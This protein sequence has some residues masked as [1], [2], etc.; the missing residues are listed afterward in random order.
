ML[1]LP[2]AVRS[3]SPAH[4]SYVGTGEVTF[5]EFAPLTCSRVYTDWEVENISF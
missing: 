2:I 4:R 1:F 5:L 3:E